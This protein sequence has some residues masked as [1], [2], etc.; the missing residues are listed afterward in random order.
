MEGLVELKKRAFIV[1]LTKGSLSLLKTVGKSV[2]IGGAHAGK[3]AFAKNFGGQ[4]A[5]GTGLTL[6]SGGPA[7]SALNARKVML[8]KRAA[9]FKMPS[10][11]MPSM[12]QSGLGNIGKS[13]PNA[14]LKMNVTK[15][16]GSRFPSTQPK[17]AL[18]IMR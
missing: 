10:L 11:K 9:P 1:P 2:G 15:Q 13:S 12:K 16:L 4:A 8:N 7:G 5:L 14:S 6:A 3:G 17:S 18:K